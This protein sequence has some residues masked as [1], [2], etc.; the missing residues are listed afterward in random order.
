[1]ELYETLSLIAQGIPPHLITLEPTSFNALMI[2]WPPPHPDD[3]MP[4]FLPLW[5]FASLLTLMPVCQPPYLGDVLPTSSL[6]VLYVHLIMSMLTENIMPS[7][8][9]IG[10]F[11]NPVFLYL[12][13][14]W[15]LSLHNWT[16][17]ETP[18]SIIEIFMKLLPL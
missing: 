8:Y 6:W 12:K 17:H 3:F 13:Y 11:M 7:S 16:I 18:P 10:I 2:F 9:I 14:A 1:M 15:T 4:T 5:H